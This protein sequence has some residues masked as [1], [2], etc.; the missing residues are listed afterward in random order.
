MDFIPS[1][2]FAAAF[3]ETNFSTMMDAGLFVNGLGFVTAHLA[4]GLPVARVTE[5]PF[6]FVSDA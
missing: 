4:P 6:W 1:E 2:M 3:A 5:S